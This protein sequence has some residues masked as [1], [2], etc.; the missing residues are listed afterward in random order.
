MGH[1]ILFPVRASALILMSITVLGGCDRDDDSVHQVLAAP[2]E[3]DARV[4]V[5]RFFRALVNVDVKTATMLM[6]EQ[7]PE[8]QGRA[9]ARIARG[10]REGTNTRVNRFTVH[11]VIPMWI[12]SEPYFRAGVSFPRRGVRGEF[13]YAFSV[14]VRDG[15]VE[16]F[17]D[18]DLG[19]SA[20]DD[21]P[22][23]TNEGDKVQI[24]DD[25]RRD[26]GL[27]TEDA[28]ATDERE[29]LEL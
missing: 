12:G 18:S 16:G 22:S 2:A 17:L 27:E 9:R 14:R 10:Q 23:T 20:L 25:T 13:L 6:C 26:G 7:D 3:A 4:I 1:A 8:S 24:D 28:A 29:V 19:I 21:V 15:C 11:S 5:N